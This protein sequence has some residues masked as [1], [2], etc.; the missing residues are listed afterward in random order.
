MFHET[1][2][3]IIQWCFVKQSVAIHDA[4]G[5]MNLVITNNVNYSMRRMFVILTIG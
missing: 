2:H 4:I 1:S 3:H 5:D